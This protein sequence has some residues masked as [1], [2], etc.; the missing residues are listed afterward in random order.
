MRISLFH[1]P[2]C[3]Q[4]PNKWVGSCKANQKPTS[5]KSALHVPLWDRSDGVAV[6]SER[7]PAGVWRTR[8]DTLLLL[9]FLFLFL[10]VVVISVLVVLIIL[11]DTIWYWWCGIHEY[12]VLISRFPFIRHV[13]TVFRRHTSSHTP[14]PHTDRRHRR[15]VLTRDGIYGAW[16]CERR[17]EERGNKALNE[18]ENEND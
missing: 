11:I 6:P 15:A 16:K 9:L 5:A 2:F 13:L 4:T 3:H 17:A 12:L 8:N 7:H 1:R 14:H 18:K 10:L